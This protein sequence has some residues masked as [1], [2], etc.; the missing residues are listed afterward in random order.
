MCGIF[1]SVGF[2]S[3]SRDSLQKIKHRGPN[4]WGEYVDKDASIYLGHQRLSVIDLSSAGRQPMGLADGNYY[5]TY[6]GEVYNFLELRKEY[7]RSEKFH[8]N[9]DTEVI[10]RM[11]NLFGLKTPQF[12]RGMFAFSVYD[13]FKNEIMLCRDRIGIKPLYYYCKDGKF[14][15]ASELSALKSIKGIDL[16]INHL[17]LDYYFRFGYIPAPFSAYKYIKKLKPGNTIIY[18]LNR[19]EMRSEE[20]FWEL[21]KSVKSHSGLSESD[22]LERISSKIEESVKLRLVSDV[23]LGAFLSGGLDSSLIVMTMA[24]IIKESLKTFT[25][26]FDYHAYDERM[27]AELIAEQF[28]TD[29]HVEVVKPNAMGIVP[30]LVDSFGEPFA[31]SSAIPTYYVAKMAKKHVTVALSGDG[32]D[33]IFAGYQ[34]YSR[35]HNYGCLRYV[36]LKIRKLIGSLG[37]VLPQEMSGHGFLRR[38]AFCDNTD[39]YQ[40]MNT[41]FY[42][43]GSAGIYNR[44]FINNLEHEGNHFFQSILDKHSGPDKKLITQLQLIDLFSYLPDDV[45]TKVDRTSMANS[46]EVRVPLLDHELVEMA[47]S[48]PADIR[49]KLKRLKNIVKTLLADNVSADVLQHKKQGFGVPVG[50]WFRNEWK[51]LMYEMIENTKNDPVVDNNVLKNIFQCH[52]TGKRDFGR[53]LYT[54]FFYKYWLLRNN[55][56]C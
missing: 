8:S 31:D 37:R 24:K 39:L 45:L 2:E 16:E 15:F 48:C 49:F 29:H 56:S 19:K 42:S 55:V 21:K 10:L 36:P 35:V 34:R 26:G 53:E 32:G 50:Q 3:S 52:L 44:E 23:P 20:P 17:G 38:Q 11:F 27:Y 12:L 6:N 54:V 7:L 30:L 22:W 40:T 18:D 43:S 5:I 33:E 4:D 46:L 9:T 13:K 47:F 14:A 1:G 25:I 51:P 28:K 41:S